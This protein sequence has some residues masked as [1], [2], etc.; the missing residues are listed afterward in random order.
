[1]NASPV[2]STPVAAPPLLSLRGYGVTYGNRRVFESIDLNVGSR[3][4]L[5]IMGPSGTGKSTLLRTLCCERLPTDPVGI[6]GEATFRGEPL[7]TSNRPVLV[8]QQ[9]PLFL[10]NV[11]DYLADGFTNRSELSREEQ[12][13]RLVAAL[14]L[15][16]LS[17]LID[18]FDARLADL[19]PIDRK[20]L[21]LVHALA[22]D[23]PLICL[24]ELTAGLDDGDAA[25][26]LSVVKDEGARRTFLMVTHH[27]GHAKLIADEVVLL[28]GGRVIEHSPSSSFFRAPRTEPA[29]QF[30]KTGGCNLPSLDVRPEHLAPECRPEPKPL[31]SGR[32]I[33]LHGEGPA[34]FRWLIDGQ[35]AGTRQPGILGD[36]EQELEALRHVGATTLV[37][38]TEKSLDVPVERFGL[39]HHWLPIKDMGAPDI[40][41]ALHLCTL[42]ER[43]IEQGGAV[44]YHCLAGHGRTGLM[45][46]VHL[47]Y[48]GMTS[49]R[50][51]AFVRHRQPQWIQ[52][53][54]QEQFLWDLELHLAMQAPLSDRA[55][56]GES[57]P[58]ANV[59]GRCWKGVT[60]K[61]QV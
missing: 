31:T 17:H 11:H 55:L 16:N 48:R 29:A 46:A 39:K 8:A 42:M 38:L 27:Q 53:V 37:S 9:L 18:T 61:S 34:G 60:T 2:A 6:S 22:S 19:R 44:V 20:C 33:R 56:A 32:V 47:V 21:S 52:S 43:E 7:G 57:G 5:A 45:L 54:S 30:L 12:G 15:A 4:I 13:R 36:M 50:V 49:P 24:D 41:A 10:S 26:L 40:E 51:L 14:R 58:I 28:A 25:Q 3:R 59:A 23:P 1:M 35:L